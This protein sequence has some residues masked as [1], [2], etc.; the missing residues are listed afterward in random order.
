MNFV[1]AQE[2]FDQM[3][4]QLEQWV[5]RHA[6][7]SPALDFGMRLLASR[8]EY[9]F[10][11]ALAG[12]FLFGWIRARPEEREGALLA[13]AAALLALLLNQLVSHAWPRHRPFDAHPHLVRLL[14]PHS[15]DRSFPSDHA[16]ASFAIAFVLF[17]RHRR[18]GIGLMAA[19]ALMGFA[20]VF[21]GVHYPLDIAGGIA[22]GFGAAA[23]LLRYRRPITDARLL[24]DRAM[25]R[26]G[27]LR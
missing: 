10:L 7:A 15:R 20:R 27:L 3:D 4:F 23:L 25:A 9:L 8:G 12:W 13:L 19:A 14:I 18:L 1:V 5:N 21:V 16:S 11:L 22:I 24:L 6:G 26:L 2:L 17:A